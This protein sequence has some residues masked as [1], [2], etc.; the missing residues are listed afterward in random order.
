MCVKHQS[1][2]EN[3]LGFKNGRGFNN[4]WKQK[5]HTY[6]ILVSKRIQFETSIQKPA[7]TKER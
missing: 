1:S 3:F 2:A 6:I 5:F 7:T 4:I